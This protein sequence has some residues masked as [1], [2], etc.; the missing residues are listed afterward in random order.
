MPRLA[1]PEL[2]A[3]DRAP[4]DLGRAQAPAAASDQGKTAPPAIAAGS[5]DT[6]QSCTGHLVARRPHPA[7]I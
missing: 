5:G 7:R 4:D 3:D 1:F 6:L 2:A